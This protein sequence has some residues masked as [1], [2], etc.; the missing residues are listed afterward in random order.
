MSFL[1]THGTAL[2]NL[3]KIPNHSLLVRIVCHDSTVF[4]HHNLVF[5]IKVSTFNTDYYALRA[6]CGDYVAKKGASPLL[7][8]FVN[9]EYILDLF[10]ILCLH[11]KCALGK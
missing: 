10:V 5:S 1:S 11:R 4:T 8:I 9:F 3:N 6:L 7:S 2:N